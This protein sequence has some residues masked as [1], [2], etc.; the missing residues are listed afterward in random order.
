MAYAIPAIAGARAMW[1]DDQLRP[2]SGEYRLALAT[3]LVGDFSIDCMQDAFTA[4]CSRHEALRM[5]FHEVDGDVVQTVVDEVDPRFLVLEPGRSGQPPSLDEVVAT[6]LAEPIPLDRAPLLR[7]VVGRSAPDTHVLMMIGHHL[8]TDGWSAEILLRDLAAAYARRRA[9]QSRTDLLPPGASL[10][11]YAEERVRRLGSARRE[12]LL[13]FWKRELT[14][15]ERPHLP[16]AAGSDE[17]QDDSSS[18]AARSVLPADLAGELRAFTR[19]ERTTPFAALVL[20]VHLVLR[21]FSSTRRIP[22][23]TAIANRDTVDSEDVVGFLANTVVLVGDL[24]GDPTFRIALRRCHDHLMDVHD[25]KELPFE[26]LVERLA[27]ARSRD[28]N[29]FTDVTITTGGVLAPQWQLVGV[30][31]EPLDL[32]YGF[33][34][35]KLVIDFTDSDAGIAVTVRYRAGQVDGGTAQWVADRLPEVLRQGLRAPDE[36]LEAQ[37]LLSE[38]QHRQVLCGWGRGARRPIEHS[39]LASVF[40]AGAVS[41]SSTVALECPGAT[42]TYGELLERAD[43]VAHWLVE[44]GAAPER[45][46]ALLMGMSPEL[47]VA[48]VAVARTG[49]AYVVVPPDDPRSRQ[50][51]ILADADPILVLTRQQILAIQADG[52]RQATWLRSAIDPRSAA[53]IVYTSGSTGTPKGVTVE[54][55]AVCNYLDHCVES[56]PGLAGRTL[57]PATMAFDFAVTMVHGTL[58]AGGRLVLGDVD[59]LAC[60]SSFAAAKFTASHFSALV[61]PDQDVAVSSD[62]L[63]GGEPVRG[64]QLHA[65]RD[66][67]PNATVV[68][69]YGPSEA[70][71]GC[72]DHR[73]RPG[74]GLSDEVVPMGR[75][76][77]NV[78][79]RLLDAR[80]QLMPPMVVGELYVA[81][82]GIARGYLGR[83]GHTAERFVADPYAGGGRRMYRTGDLARWTH[84][85]LLQFVG[86]TDTQVKVRGYRVELGEVEAVLLRHPGVT[87]AAVLAGETAAASFE[88]YVAGSGLAE[89]E[90]R[91]HLVDLLPPPM[92]PARI[93]VVDRIPLMRSGKIDCAALRRTS[94]DHRQQP[95]RPPATRVERVVADCWRE[96]LGVP[97]VAADD[98]FFA[99]GGHSLAA[100]RV[101][102]MINDRLRVQL[103]RNALFLHPTVARLAR[104]VSGSTEGDDRC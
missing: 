39:S 1:L 26:V 10:R 50:E 13:R 51:A 90:L 70:T 95:G 11:A 7:I 12:E 41:R 37:P 8:I 63:F 87:S 98:N 68:S 16:R 64:A 30:C 57:A 14:D 5:R 34:K 83:P 52:P 78:E 58:A 84:D 82:A 18:A 76:I 24:T 97:G 54:N 93:T 88:A 22:V 67:H 40:E 103:A 81:G 61:D 59:A 9:G 74:S 2:D 72:C 66:R 15:L 31:S 86:R 33:P 36:P 73:V 25:H 71:V 104:Q 65:W 92:I 35:A 28:A 6:Q 17:D 42:V 47:I 4:L 49:S 99:L 29:P 89:G 48:M 44:H 56:Y 20:A 94:V 80:L 85:G 75:P 79:V 77:R 43:R 60:S 69:H 27:P 96:V 21:A 3:R 38:D 19:V 91:A 62:L 46:V 101:V 53:Y 102:R 100:L 45:I 55:A 23:T 32:P